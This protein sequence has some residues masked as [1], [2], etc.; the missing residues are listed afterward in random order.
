M[1]HTVSVY[2]IAPPNNPLLKNVE[3]TFTKMFVKLEICFD[4]MQKKIYQFLRKMENNSI[5]KIDRTNVCK[6]YIRR[7]KTMC[8][9][10]YNGV[11]HDVNKNG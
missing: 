1:H 11:I 9:V 2:I 5:I 3:F 7:N 8:I 10:V 4:G 6:P